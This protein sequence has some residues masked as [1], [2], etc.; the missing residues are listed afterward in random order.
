MVRLP[1]AQDNLYH[2]PAVLRQAGV[3]G[4]L[5]GEALATRADWTPQLNVLWITA[6]YSAPLAAL[7]WWVR[8]KVPAGSSS[9]RASEQGSDGRWA[10][11][12]PGVAFASQKAHAIG[13]EEG[14]HPLKNWIVTHG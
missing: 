9:G 2:I 3:H 8:G 12:W 4:Q 1:S 14:A 6:C 11:C 5:A 13:M 7:S 10:P